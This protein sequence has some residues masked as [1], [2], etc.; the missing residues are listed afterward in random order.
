MKSY[1]HIVM[2][3]SAIGYSNAHTL[4]GLKAG[5]VET[6][7]IFGFLSTILTLSE[8]FKTN[9]FVFCWDSKGSLREEVFP[10]YKAKRKEKRKSGTEEEKQ[11]YGSVKSQLSKLEKQILPQIGFRNSFSQPGFEADDLIADIV[12]GY[13]DCLMV[14]SDEDMF[15][16]L[17]YADMYKPVKKELWNTLLFRKTYGIPPAKWVDVKSVGGCTSDEVPGV[18]GIGE[19]RAL[20][21]LKGELKPNSMALTN[22]ITNT[23]IIDRNRKLVTLPYPGTPENILNRD[24]FHIEELVKIAEEYWIDSFLSR[25]GLARW[26]NFF[27]RRTLCSIL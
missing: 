8:T 16:M 11:F 26:Q 6:G 13:D 20:K 27:D 1:N 7:V 15:Q 4:K 24:K 17:D 9:H 22:I 18:P 10:E 19:G 14:T 2:D 3:C 12:M 25:I 5:E 23:D 21:Y